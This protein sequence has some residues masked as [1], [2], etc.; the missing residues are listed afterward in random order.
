M[1]ITELENAQKLLRAAAMVETEA[2][3]DNAA[4][5]ARQYHLLTAAATMEAL[6]QLLTRLSAAANA[7]AHRL[8]AEATQA[9]AERK[10]LKRKGGAA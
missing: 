7:E 3:G 6:S 10:E 9:E 8:E 4:D 5:T 2:R 1:N